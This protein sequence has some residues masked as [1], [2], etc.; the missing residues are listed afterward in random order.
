MVADT[1]VT[2]I[3]A[4][5]FVLRLQGVSWVGYEHEP[6]PKCVFM[7]QIQIGKL[8]QCYTVLCAHLAKNHSTRV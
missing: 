7:I 5:K 1:Q 4:A 8:A 2:N 6:G 3:Q